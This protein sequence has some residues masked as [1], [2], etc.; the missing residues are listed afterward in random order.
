MPNKRIDQFDSAGA[1]NDA[2]YVPVSQGNL[3]KKAL[4]SD[5]KNYVLMDQPTFSPFGTSIAEAASADEGRAIL[6]IPGANFL[7]NGCFRVWQRGTSFTSATGF[8]NNDATALLDRWV[9]LSDGNDIVDLSREATVKPSDAAYSLKLDV[10]TADKRFLVTQIVPFLDAIYMAGRQATFAVEVCKDAG[11]TT[12]DSV[13]LMLLE[14]TGT[15]DAPTRDFVS[16][17]ETEGSAPT[18]VSNWSIVDSEVHA[19]SDSFAEISIAGTFSSSMKNCAVAVMVE[20]DDGTVGDLVYVGKARHTLG[21]N[22]V[23]VEFRPFSAEINLCR[24]TFWKTFPYATAP[25]QNA[26]GG[27]GVIMSKANGTAGIWALIVSIWFPVL[28]LKSPTMTFYS[29]AAASA[30]WYNETAG[31]AGPSVSS[32]VTQS[33][34]RVWNNVGS[35]TD[36][37]S[38]QLH[39]IAD[40]EL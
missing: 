40:A 28:M 18:V 11:N 21:G 2:N 38:Y 25:A 35:V 14:W 4:L 29:P 26:G 27:A 20:N 7:A 13:R 15:A 1:L 9:L 33:G 8:A 39:A 10:E 17:W 32:Q 31:A 36:N 12:V 6:E 30:D 19:L 22:P 23:P 37:N 5:I 34:F 16:S 3:A 24:R